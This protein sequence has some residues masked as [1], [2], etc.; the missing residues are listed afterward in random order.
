M[1]KLPAKCLQNAGKMRVKRAAGTKGVP[2]G[3][4]YGQI[5]LEKGPKGPFSIKFG[6]LL[7]L[8][9]GGQVCVRDANISYI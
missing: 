9:G 8:C 3:G 6:S 7:A 4:M 1:I 2:C 5:F